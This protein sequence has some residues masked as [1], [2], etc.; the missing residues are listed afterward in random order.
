MQESTSMGHT[1]P[2]PSGRYVVGQDPPEIAGG[3]QT[4][5]R[6][7]VLPNPLTTP[8][9]SSVDLGLSNDD[10]S[11][12]PSKSSRTQSPS[13]NLLRPSLMHSRPSSSICSTTFALEA[14]RDFRDSASSPQNRKASEDSASAASED[15]QQKCRRK[16]LTLS[17]NGYGAGVIFVVGRVIQV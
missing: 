5:I 13:T 11:L 9:P 4:D 15:Y 6:D 3:G 10:L 17:E 16:D 8:H 1:I 2:P 12:L 7:S 14:S